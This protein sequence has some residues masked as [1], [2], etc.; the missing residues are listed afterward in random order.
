MREIVGDREKGVGRKRIGRLDGENII[1]NYTTNN[2]Y[3]DN[4]TTVSTT[5]TTTL[6]SQCHDLSILLLVRTISYLSF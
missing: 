3:S 6:R 1:T 5:I 2:N 4:T